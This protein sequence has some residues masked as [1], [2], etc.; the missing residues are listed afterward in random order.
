MQALGLN[1][2][3]VV[4]C[5]TGQSLLFSVDAT[6]VEKTPHQLKM[7]VDGERVIVRENFGFLRHAVLERQGTPSVDFGENV[8]AYLPLWRNGGDYFRFK[9]G[10]RLQGNRPWVYKCRTISHL[11][12]FCTSHLLNS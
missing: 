4:S 9:S 11:T 5:S 10:G 8:G 1:V 2:L 12:F 3:S 7:F 6:I